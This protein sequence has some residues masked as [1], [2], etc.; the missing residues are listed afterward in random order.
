MIAPTPAP[1]P[2]RLWPAVWK[3]LH[4]RLEIAFRSF[5]RAR[6]GRKAILIVFWLVIAA[7]IVGIFY[8]S[9]KALDFLRSPELEQFLGELGG[10][11]ETI[12]TLF[13]SAA[14][15]GIFMTSFGVLLQALY[16]SGD[17]DFLLSTPVPIRAVFV[18]KLLQAILP[19]FALICLFGLPMLF[20][21][22][23]SSGYSILYYPLVL[24]V[25]SALALAGAGLSS[26]LV[27]A[28]VRVF[29][30]R[31]VAEVIAFFGA[32]FSI[33]C[34]QSGQLARYGDFSEQQAAQT[35][36]MIERV[37][38][39]WS[40]L[41][42]GGRGLVA[43]GTGD[44]LTGFGLTGLTLG[45]SAAAFVISLVTAERLYYNGWAG[46]QNFAR[47]KKIK[48]NMTAQPGTAALQSISQRLGSFL[49]VR[50]RAIVWK[51]WIVLR[52]DLRNMSQLI[53]AIIFGIIYAIMMFSGE[54]PN[55]TDFG[56]TPAWLGQIL[57]N[58]QTY[59]TVGLSL[60]VG[61][62]LL[63][64]LAGMAFSQEGKSYW[65][66]KTA[67]LSAG[68][69]IIAKYLVAYIPTLALSVL[70]LTGI[71]LLSKSGV[72][73]LIYSA[74]A[75]A[76]ALAGNAGLN[77]AFGIIGANLNWQDPRQMQRTSAGCLGSLAAMVY[78]PVALLLFFLP[79]VMFE[80]FGLSTAIGQLI[81][82][83]LGSLVC[84][85][86]AIIPLLFAR[87]RVENL[88]YD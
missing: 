56:D 72:S 73:V 27:M 8:L 50:I 14:F 38:T 48:R 46:M 77:L 55:K 10:W 28:V 25:I 87:S 32:I 30:A 81:G 63:G 7:A 26:L 42:W 62:M 37:N 21:L 69:L 51:D 12:P 85:A 84:L 41:S 88:G 74:L 47:K 64:R 67:P 80:I 33:I 66:L 15:I 18:A 39:P 75:V 40:P 68:Q 17:M 78:L 49:P 76:L 2:L 16:L 45:L 19:N 36:A 6:R 34:S 60:L 70:Y 23:V 29:P 57:E 71:W 61:W 79:P 54:S 35:L 59:A 13:V 43:I 31:R 24:L 20:G 65:L 22:G 3:L 5:R 4:L 44:W 58:T 53:T 52:R 83:V 86:V 82:L 11:V 9:W 1:A